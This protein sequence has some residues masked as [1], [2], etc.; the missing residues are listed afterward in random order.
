MLEEGIVENNVPN[1]VLVE[2]EDLVALRR[3][4][5]QLMQDH[6]Y[7]VLLTGGKSIISK[8]ARELAASQDFSKRTV[9]MAI[10]VE[11][12]WS[13]ILANLY[14]RVNKPKL[15]TKIFDEREDAVDWLRLRYGSIDQ[16]PTN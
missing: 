12:R 10:V 9:A 1:G 7:C 4:N 16:N 2:T 5:I 15:K 13:R 11:S 3:A 8:E 14:I 6:P